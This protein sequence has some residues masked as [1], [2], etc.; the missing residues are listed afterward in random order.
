MRETPP[1]IIGAP[2]VP[3]LIRALPDYAIFGFQGAVYY[4]GALYVSSNLGLLVVKDRRLTALYEWSRGDAVIEGPWLD[5]PGDALWAQ[6]ARDG[7]LLRFDGVRWQRI[8]LPTPR[9]GYS[10]GDILNGFQGISGSKSF[11]ILGG[12]LIWRAEKSGAE[13][14][15]EPRPAIPADS[16]VTAFF[17]LG[18]TLAM[19]VPDVYVALRLRSRRER[20][21]SV[22]VF[23]PSGWKKFATLDVDGRETLTVGQTGY[24]RTEEGV[25]YAVTADKMTRLETPAPCDA[26]AGTSAGALLASFGRSGVFQR[27]ADRWELRVESPFPE[28]EGP[29]RVHLAESAGEIALVTAPKAGLNVTSRELPPTVVRSGTAGIWISRGKKFEPVDFPR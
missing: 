28:S 15:P 12:G 3:G 26:I 16:R 7:S 2:E 21:A 20:P 24:L 4:H 29:H 1:K 14:I 10:R 25:L 11:W 5:R 6:Q 19:L 22:Y 23:E 27:V 9:A 17:P 8:Q 18:D 13:W